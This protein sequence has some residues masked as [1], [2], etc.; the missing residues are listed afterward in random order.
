MGAPVGSTFVVGD[1]VV[2]GVV[3]VVAKVGDEVGDTVGMLVAWPVGAP[4][5]GNVVVVGAVVVV[6]K[7]GDEVGDTVGML[8]ARLLCP[9]L[10]M[11]LAFG[12]PNC[13]SSVKVTAEHHISLGSFTSMTSVVMT[14]DSSKVTN[15][16]DDDDEVAEL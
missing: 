4:V 14:V 15:A 6:A 16:S 2:V 9:W 5:V 13:S 12:I 8:V 3:V 1:A 7:V 10:I 11:R